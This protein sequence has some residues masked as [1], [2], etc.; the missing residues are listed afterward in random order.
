M[1][2]RT[3]DRSRWRSPALGSIGLVA[4]VLLAGSLAF[5][6]PF[7]KTAQD[8]VC[9]TYGGGPFEGE[10]FQRVVQPGSSLFF[11]GWRDKL[12]CYPT[13][14]RLYSIDER[15]EAADEGAP[16]A[17][18]AFTDDPVEARWELNVYFT[19]CQEPEC[20]HE[21]HESIGKKTEAF[22]DTGWIEMLNDYMLPQIENVVARES[23]TFT[24][25]ELAEDEEAILDVQRALAASL[26]DNVSQA[27]G[28]EFFCG[29]DYQGIGDECG[30]F[31]VVLKKPTLPDEVVA[32]FRNNLTSSIEIQT[33]QNEI[34]QREAEAEA[35]AKLNEAL[36][37]SGPAYVYIRCIETQG[38]QIPTVAPFLSGVDLGRR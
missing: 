8:K 27:L 30:D 20:V 15:P 17:V 24:A 23:R 13:T 18:V 16:S 34:A 31:E 14:Q 3:E 26:R 32:S 35:I 7:D 6:W 25:Q 12:Y 22:T 10:E 33:K 37:R 29:P 4:G 9:I 2:D 28:G 21:F 36:E 11:N 38:C 1:A 19:L 5:M